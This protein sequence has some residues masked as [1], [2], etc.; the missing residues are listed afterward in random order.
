MKRLSLK[1]LAGCLCIIFLASCE[2]PYHPDNLDTGE[3]IPAIQGSLNNGPGPCQ[4][5]LYWASPFG[6]H[7]Q[8]PIEDAA[9][10]ILDDMGNREPLA[11]LTPG[12]YETSSDDFRGIPGR[13]YTLH[14]VLPNGDIYESTPTP[15]DSV[16]LTYSLY[17]RIGTKQDYV[18]DDYGNFI[19]TAYKGLYYYVDMTLNTTQQHFYAYNTRMITQFKV[20]T[21]NHVFFIWKI[22]Y[23]NTIPNI[24]A[25]IEY[26][27]KAMVKEHLLGF[28]TYYEN[29]DLNPVNPPRPAGWVLITSIYSISDEV[30]NY[31]QSVVKQ[32]NSNSQIFDPVP[33][34]VTGNIKCLNDPSKKAL[35]VFEVAFKYSKNIGVFW[36]PGYEIIRQV[37]LSPDYEGPAYDGET[38][39]TPPDFW[40]EF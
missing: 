6:N 21:S 18:R 17:E 1:T 26:N 27:D 10:S 4:L 3:R 7:R 38:A 36:R 11:M 37:E 15:L 28:M 34:Q 9:V 31:Y 2:K 12:V 8:D 13:T 14:L 19:F 16:P 35:G 30:Y 29:R 23:L 39:D 20:H 25:T 24:K 5:T 22:S 40:V 32:L 33:S